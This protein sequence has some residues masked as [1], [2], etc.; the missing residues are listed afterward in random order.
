MEKPG[1]L[2]VHGAWHQPSH[3]ENVHCQLTA[4]GYQVE[5]PA[6]PSA[7]N[8]AVKDVLTKDVVIVKESIHR[9]AD[10][11][12]DV[13]MICHSY[14]GIIG[15]EA[16]AEFIEETK[17][18]QGIGCIKHLVLVAAVVLPKGMSLLGS[19]LTPHA[20]DFDNGLLHH[21]EPYH[22]F[23]QQCSTKDARNAMGKVLPQIAES[24][25]TETR[26]CGWADYEIP[27]TYIACTLDKALEYD[28]DIL[29]F[30]NRLEDAGVKSLTV[31]KLETDHSP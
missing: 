15:S 29:M 26:H 23:Y 21:L 4:A 6:S 16:V 17:G 27:V 20:L 8:T 25:A 10:T 31:H 7:S 1:V 9:I 24:F 22:R 11:G 3:W 19:R 14:G 30:L 13:V 18:K 2:I 28:T 12:K 5:A